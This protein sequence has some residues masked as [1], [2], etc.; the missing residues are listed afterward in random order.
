M[1]IASRSYV[2]CIS[3]INAASLRATLCTKNLV[4][5]IARKMFVIRLKATHKYVAQI[6]YKYKEIQT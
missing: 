3:S 5:K 6:R 4:L 2:F 1:Y